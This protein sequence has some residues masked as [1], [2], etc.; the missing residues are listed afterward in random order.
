M[1]GIPYTQRFWKSLD[2]DTFLIHRCEACD[3]RFFPPSPIC[4]YCQSDAVNWIKASGTGTIYS[5]TRQ[6]VTGAEFDDSI[7]AGIIE[8]DDDVRILTRIDEPYDTLS[9]GDR[10]KI[11]PVEYDQEF[12]RGWT[13]EFPYFAAVTIA[14]SS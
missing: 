11:T 7:V 4:P 9:I 12:D 1:L 14:P 10:V 2:D 8:L 6:H 3:E 13:S 5:F